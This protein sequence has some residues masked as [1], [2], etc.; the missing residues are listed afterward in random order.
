MPEDDPTVLVVEDNPDHAL[1]IQL[2][3]ERTL[4]GLDV[5]V[6]ENGEE[7]VAYLGGEAPYEDRRENPLPRLVILDLIMPKLDGFGV[8]EWISEQP[9]L[10]DVP[11][12]V[13]T[14]S[15]NP[16]DEAR[17]LELGART[18]LSKPSTLDELGTLV[19][20]LVQKWL[21]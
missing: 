3:A 1:L 19:Q 17:S 21:T 6:A 10:E 20:E 8:L 9:D 7:A 15:L 12:V 5:R 2:A 16:R 11:V 4:P 13:F 14:S 18:F